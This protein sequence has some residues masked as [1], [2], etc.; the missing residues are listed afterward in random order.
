ELSGVKASL[1]RRTDLGVEFVHVV[2]QSDA[3]A[4]SHRPT[5]RVLQPDH[6]PQVGVGSIGELLVEVTP[7]N[8]DQIAAA[9]ASAE[10]ETRWEQADNRRMRAKPSRARSEVGAIRALRT[11]GPD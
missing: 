6:V 8:V 2:L 9:I 7:E 11:H 10:P 5:N 1:D 3:W 4:K